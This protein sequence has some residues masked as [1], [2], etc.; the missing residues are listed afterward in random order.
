MSSKL[1]YWHK[2]ANSSFFKKQYCLITYIRLIGYAVMLTVLLWILLI[3]PFSWCCLLMFCFAFFR[4]S[5]WFHWFS[6][7]SLYSISL[8]FAL[9]FIYFLP[10]AYFKFNY[11]VFFK[12]KMEAL[13]SLIL[14]NF[15]FLTRFYK[16][17]KHYLNI[18]HKFFCY[19]FTW[20]IF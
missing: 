1:N 13:R 9:V 7:L 12:L 16:I 2:I 6:L 10:F 17:S 3:S 14:D 20:S 15:S 18:P 5:F 8:I 11:L 19:A 4:T